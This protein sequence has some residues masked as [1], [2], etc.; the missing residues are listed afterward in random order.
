MAKAKRKEITI[1]PIF[2]HYSKNQ[3][4]LSPVKLKVTYNRTTKNYPIQYGRKNVF[5][6]ISQWESLKERKSKGEN[7]LLMN[8]ID[9]YRLRAIDVAEQIT[10]DSR[11]FSF[12]QFEKDFFTNES[13]KGFISVFK[14]Y[15]DSLLVEN[16]IGTY[17]TYKCAFDAFK[18]FIEKEE[19]SPYDITAALLKDFESHIINER[20]AGQTTVGIYIRTIRIIYNICADQDR[21]LKESY[22]FGNDKR[23]KFKIIDTRKGNKKGD[24]LTIEQL[25][26][27]VETKTAPESPQAEA[28]LYW[29]LSLHC[30][31]INFKDIAHLL[32]TDLKDNIISYT[33]HKTKRTDSNEVIQVPVTEELNSII[34][35]LENKNRNSSDYIFPILSKSIKDPLKIESIISQKIKTTNKWLKRLCQE[36]ELPAV[37]TYWARHTYAS[38]LKDS[39]IPVDMI[40]ELLGHSDVKTTEH[41][42]KRFDILKKREINK[43]LQDLIL[44]H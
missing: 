11:P 33:R 22:P 44:K 20:G 37:T 8:H 4:D 30:Q 17:R 38:L 31:G 36:N 21:S 15:L 27:F 14:K 32:D 3:K 28:K 19:V 43:S 41:Y 16:R 1:E 9:S 26:K 6:S 35:K 2:W 18:E 5:L 24:A 29:L 25:R 7:R 12:I 34:E 39:G 42:L 23:G 40:R 10:K 13:S